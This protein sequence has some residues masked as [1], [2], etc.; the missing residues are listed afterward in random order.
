MFSDNG[1]NFLGASSELRKEFAAFLK[2]AATD[3]NSKHRM[4]GLEW[5]FIPPS[6]PHMGGLWEAAVKSFK[7]HLLKIAGK[8]KFNFEEF[9][10]LL[11]R[12]EAV[13]NSRPISSMTNDPNDFL[14]LTPGHFLGLSPLDRRISLIPEPPKENLS[15]INRWEK[16]KTLHHQFSI[17]WKE[18][19]LKELHKRY[20]WQSPDR[21]LEIGEMVVLQDENLPPMEW[22]LGR[23]LETFPGR[24]GKV[25]AADVRTASGVLRR[26]IVKIVPLPEAPHIKKD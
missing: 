19:Y 5:K 9:T 6:A 21:N 18:E 15:L 23:V 24:D 13:L 14:P 26:P 4:A 12:I 2:S 3:M 11:A 1:T 17:R 20:K 8:Q 16:I 25:R 7:S 22:K 10:T